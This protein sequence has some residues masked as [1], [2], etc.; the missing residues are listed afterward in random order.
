MVYTGGKLNWL[1]GKYGISAP[2]KSVPVMKLINTHKPKTR[3]ELYELI[4]S[5]Y[6]SPCSCGIIS[7]GTIKDFGEN[8][9]ESQKPAWG[10]YLFSLQ[11]CIQ[12]EYD[13]F[14]SQSL[15]GNRLEKMALSKLN[16]S[17][18]DLSFSEA[19]GFLD[20]D[21]RIDILIKKNGVDIGG[22]QVKP[23]TFINMREPVKLRHQLSNKEYGKPVF[24]LYYGKNENFLNYKEIVK[25][26][27]GL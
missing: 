20:E 2:E 26:I 10:N 13:L 16:G 22:I 19:G 3:F 11:E 21:F 8:L 23:D 17:I 12:W 1:N 14:V 27:L 15:K 7:K 9:F 24:Y 6:N 18:K 5:H 25:E 4:R